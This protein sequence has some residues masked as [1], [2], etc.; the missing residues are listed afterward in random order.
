MGRQVLHQKQKQQ[1]T[2][3]S[4]MS[5]MRWIQTVSVLALVLC[6]SFV[7]S[8]VVPPAALLVA[9][10]PPPPTCPSR[11][12]SRAQRPQWAMTMTDS[13]SVE[14]VV[15]DASNKESIDELEQN[16]SRFR[17]YLNWIGKNT[18][19]KQ[20]TAKQ[21]DRELRAME[22]R[23]SSTETPATKGR[24]HGPTIHPDQA[25]YGVVAEAFAKANLGVEGAEMAANILNR[26][27]IHSNNN[28]G[29]VLYTSVMKAWALADE[30]DKA[31][32]ILSDLEE[33]HTVDGALAPDMIAYTVYLNVLSDTKSKTG[34]QIATEALQLLGEMHAKADSGENVKVRPNTYTYTAVMKCLA[35]AKDYAGIRALFDDLKKR[36]EEAPED[37]KDN[38]RPG[39]LVYGTMIGLYAESDLGNEGADRADELL[40]ELQ[41]QFQETKNILYRP[42]PFIYASVLLAHSRVTNKEHLDNAV[43][44]VD[45]ILKQCKQDKHL[46]LDTT[47]LEAGKLVVLVTNACLYPLVCLS[48]CSPS[49]QK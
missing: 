21:M 7:D 18:R 30:F 23:S 44:R 20:Q 13:S 38:Y 40:K 15:E 5:A 41:E 25:C 33:R 31:R 29:I 24:Y 6:P 36:L 16:L 39:K 37:E 3:R 47:I 8:F 11:H 14:E 35:R 12:S 2:T 10:P 34:K 43:K 32:Q 28:A 9:P 4:T 45:E 27:Q 26:C 19:S 48:H 17:G 49:F 1:Y 42:N 46:A 22:E